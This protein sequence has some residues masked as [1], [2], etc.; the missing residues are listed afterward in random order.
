MP[1]TR[2]S[3]RERGPGTP[4]RN[5]AQ[6]EQVASPSGPPK[7]KRSNKGGVPMDEDNPFA[8]VDEEMAEA[9]TE[10]EKDESE[11]GTARK[12]TVEERRARI[13][14]QKETGVKTKKGGVGAGKGG[15]KKTKDGAAGKKKMPAPRRGRSVDSSASRASSGSRRRAPS[16]SKRARSVDSAF[17]TVNGDGS[18]DS[19][20][21]EDS[22]ASKRKKTGGRKS[23]SF[24]KD[25]QD[26]EG[27]TASTKKVAKEKKKE[28]ESYA[29]K[30]KLP[31]KT[32]W[33]YNTVI[34]Y[35]MKIGPCKSTRGEVYGRLSKAFVILQKQDPT[36]AIGDIYNAKSTPLRTPGSF[37]QVGDHGK[38]CRH[39]TVDG[40]YEWQWDDGIK[41]NQMRT[42]VGSYILLS[43][44]DPVDIF[45]WARV[46]LRGTQ[47]EYEIKPMQELYTMLGYVFLGVHANAHGP[48]VVWDFRRQ[49]VLAEL[50]L[51]EAKVAYENDDDENPTLYDPLFEKADLDWSALDFPEMRAVR[52]Y[53]KGGDWEPTER[54]KD[55]SWKFAIHVE[56]A[57]QCDERIKVAVEYLRQKGG[58]G[59]LFGDQAILEEVIND[60]ND[61]GGK[62]AFRELIPKHQNTNRSVGNAVLSGFVNIDFPVAIC[63]QNHKEGE[64]RKFREMTMRDVLHKLY[65]KLDGRKFPVFLYCFRNYRDQYQIF[66]W[67]KVPEIREFVKGIIQILP[68]YI[69]HT[70]YRWGWDMGSVKRL[71]DNSFTSD[72]SIRAQNS[73]WSKAKNKVVEVVSG[74]DADARLSFGTSPFI[75][76]KDEDMKQARPAKRIKIVH[77][78]ISPGK[79]GGCDIDDGIES[80]GGQSNADTV[81]QEGMG[82]YNG[83]DDV[84][85]MGDD[86]GF[87]EEDEAESE[88][89]DTVHEGGYKNEEDEDD[90]DEEASDEEEDEDD[91]S[92]FGTM[93]DLKRRGRKISSDMAA[94]YELEIET[95]KAAN[96]SMQTTFLEQM[97]QMQRQFQ[98]ELNMLRQQQ[99]APNVHAKSAEP[100][101]GGGGGT[102]GFDSQG[103]PFAGTPAGDE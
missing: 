1:D 64:T 31:P 62:N 45:K 16:K 18:K 11:G 15:L 29:A 93:D 103:K 48:N 80:V 65:I 33:I 86:E 51:L 8:T 81:Y 3:K 87:E 19:E 40:E 59:R 84:S 75:L 89:E 96:E 55:T 78:N 53:P 25:I 20:D 47:G 100:G 58:V 37:P 23:A 21:S 4:L 14:K 24:A 98:E 67:D 49:L 32:S 70:C 6:P 9:E 69:W 34:K 83:D 10:V 72:T 76:E 42:F 92:T 71:F 43:D 35:N 39:F 28:K 79:Q 102:G 17:S 30:A 97:A 52:T 77:S 57:T 12:E 41:G 101:A 74:T 82:D 46:D 90:D 85:E 56:Y 7:P 68:S 94:A 5:A 2:R 22:Q 88:A 27:K 60:P 38:F 99:A 91:N 44:K 54:G 66:F 73:Q 36:C 63:F 50:E 13:A 26:N 95:L 61:I